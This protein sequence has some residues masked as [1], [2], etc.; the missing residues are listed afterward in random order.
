MRGT[1]GTSKQ[2][3]A[4]LNPLPTGALCRTAGRRLLCED[5][6]SHAGLRLFCVQSS[7]CCHA[8]QLQHKM[9]CRRK[10]KGPPPH[11]PPRIAITGTKPVLW[12][13]NPVAAGLAGLHS[14]ATNPEETPPACVVP[15]SSSLPLSTPSSLPWHRPTA[16]P[17]QRVLLAQPS[18]LT[19]LGFSLLLPFLDWKQAVQEGKTSSLQSLSIRAWAARSQHRRSL[20]PVSGLS[21]SQEGLT[22]ADGQAALTGFSPPQRYRQQL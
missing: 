6:P 9:N 1:R 17:R 15:S 10:A 7:S 20:K 8:T 18:A 3:Q 12:M 16:C 19:G 4:V 22:P 14:P 5:S 21:M 13:L 2:L 11:C